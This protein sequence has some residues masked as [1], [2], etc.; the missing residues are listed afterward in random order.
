VPVI[1]YQEIKMMMMMMMVICRRKVTG[2][3]VKETEI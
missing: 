2:V 3:N 1:G